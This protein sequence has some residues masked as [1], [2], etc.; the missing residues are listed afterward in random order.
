MK[1]SRLF[2]SFLGLAV[3]TVTLSAQTAAAA[4]APA[5]PAAP[6]AVKPVKQLPVSRVAWINSSAFLAEE[7]GIKQLVRVLKE[8]E[9]EFSGTQSEL[10][11]MGEKLRTMSGELNKLQAG[12]DANAAAIQ[13]KQ[14]VA[15][16]LYG[17]LQAKQQQAQAAV[18]QA[19]QE[20]QGPVSVEISK[21]LGAFTKEREIGLLFDVAKMNEGIISAQPELEVTNDF[22]AYYNALHP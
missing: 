10:S 8:L 11:L 16:K 1:F 12:G 5:K 3:A 6:A 21:A 22:I 15:Q 19:Q 4:A 9:L 20:K 14:A 7:G 17:E 2:L 18:Q 13:E